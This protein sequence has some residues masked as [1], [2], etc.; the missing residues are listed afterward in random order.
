MLMET[1][2]KPIRSLDEIDIR[3]DILRDKVHENEKEIRT[4]WN[5]LFRKPDAF[6]SSLPSKRFTSLI[7]TGAGVLDGVIL[8]WK[9]YRKFKKRKH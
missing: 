1:I 5:S 8:G 4:L 7:S 6:T 9:L 3:K 2:Q